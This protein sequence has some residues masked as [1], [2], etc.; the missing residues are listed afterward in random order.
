VADFSPARYGLE[1]VDIHPPA[2]E[3]PPTEVVAATGGIET[4]CCGQ[5]SQEPPHIR[6]VGVGGLV[7]PERCPMNRRPGHLPLPGVVERPAAV[8]RGNRTCHG[9]AFGVPGPLHDV[10]PGATAEAVV[11]VVVEE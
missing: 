4:P 3:V 5:G 1:H 2:G 11:P 10:A 6:A 9:E 8:E 7:T